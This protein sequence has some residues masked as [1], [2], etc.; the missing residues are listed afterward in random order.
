MSQS[1]VDAQLREEARRFELR[2]GCESCVHFAPEGTRCANGYP[3]AP[4]LHIDLTRVQ[5][6]EFC[7]E[8]EVA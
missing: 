1:P 8:F 6:L 5:S 3:T 2:F 7:K 4:H